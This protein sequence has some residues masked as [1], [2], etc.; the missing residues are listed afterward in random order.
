MDHR[1]AF[2]S[3]R[4]GQVGC[5]AA[6]GPHSLVTSSVSR[7]MADDGDACTALVIPLSASASAVAAATSASNSSS[8]MAPASQDPER[9]HVGA[10]HKGARK[11]ALLGEPVAAGGGSG[12]PITSCAS[13]AVAVGAVC[14]PFFAS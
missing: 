7:H 5:Q 9:L 2:C 12:G 13:A 10:V 1:A 11:I 8:S 14:S 3:M 4:L 6:L